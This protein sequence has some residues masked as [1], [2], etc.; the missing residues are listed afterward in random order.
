MVKRTHFT[1][2]SIKSMSKFKDALYFKA[3]GEMAPLDFEPNTKLR[4]VEIKC[5]KLSRNHKLCGIAELDVIK[6]HEIAFV[7]QDIIFD[8]SFTVWNEKKISATIEYSNFTRYLEIN[9]DTQSILDTYKLKNGEV[10]TRKLV[11]SFEKL[12]SLSKL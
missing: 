4:I 7:S 8:D 3:T 12:G 10:R 9:I 6:G 1:A 5:Y 11:S 2:T